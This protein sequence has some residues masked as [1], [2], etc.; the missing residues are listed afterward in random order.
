M[1]KTAVI[2]DLHLA[3]HRYLGGHLRGGLNDRARWIINAFH[4]ALQLAEDQG[5]SSLVVAGD[6]FDVAKP[7]P[8]LIAAVADVIGTRP[9]RASMPVNLLLGNHDMESGEE[10]ALMPFHHLPTAPK[11]SQYLGEVYDQPTMVRRPDRSMSTEDQV[12]MAP[13]CVGPAS[14][15]LRIAINADYY[16]PRGALLVT[17]VGLIDDDTPP[18]LRG[19]DDA[20]HVDLLD[21]LCFNAGIPA[22]I[23]GN[24]HR[25]KVIRG[26]RGTLMI[27]A[28]ALVPTGFDNQGLVG[29]GTVTIYDHESGEFEVHEIPGPRFIKTDAPIKNVAP[30][31]G[32]T[33]AYRSTTTRDPG[34]SSD[35]N[36]H[37][38]WAPPAT[39]APVAHDKARAVAQ[40]ANSIAEAVV[41]YVDAVTL[42]P[43]I[44][45]EEVKRQCWTY[46]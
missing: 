28:G 38:E 43:A 45:R 5:C 8:A 7:S 23:A 9:T 1:G 14:D 36:V 21:E 19:A 11:G 34:E 12:L 41:A 24:W 33:Y 16:D 35:P 13:F 31:A 25:A 22:V 10:H 27:Q 26:K 17:H 3:N 30:P 2:A 29:Y 15:W 4:G 37:I 42:D 20:I 46:L 39:E 44:D 32:M 40:T 6:L 18:F